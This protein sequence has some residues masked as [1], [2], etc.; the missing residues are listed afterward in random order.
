MSFKPCPALLAALVTFAAVLPA[1]AQGFN[2]EEVKRMQARMPNIG[3]PYSIRVTTGAVTNEGFEKDLT[4]TDPNLRHWCWVPVTTARQAYI[5][6]APGQVD[7]G[8]P[9]MTRPKSVYAASK[10]VAVP[11]PTVRRW[12]LQYPRQIA[13]RGGSH[14]ASDVH[15]T[16]SYSKEPARS[17]AQETKTYSYSDVSARLSAPRYNTAF[18][19]STNVSGKLMR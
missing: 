8:K 15:G 4:N 10:P 5:H 17:I 9:N 18:E 11:L 13:S 2:P 6:M 16:V 12:D 3:R 19:A 7:H 1:S 14:S